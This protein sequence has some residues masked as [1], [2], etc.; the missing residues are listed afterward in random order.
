MARS[1]SRIESVHCERSSDT[2]GV[3]RSRRL[4]GVSHG[5]FRTIC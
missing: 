1:R 5:R 3:S 2:R 4:P